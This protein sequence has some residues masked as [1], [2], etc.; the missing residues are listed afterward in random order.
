MADYL[1]SVGTEVSDEL[2]AM[3]YVSDSDHLP[4]QVNFQF[5]PAAGGVERG[6]ILFEPY[7]NGVEVVVV[8]NDELHVVNKKMTFDDF[9]SDNVTKLVL[10]AID[11]ANA[12]LRGVKVESK[13]LSMRDLHKLI[14]DEVSAAR[15][16]S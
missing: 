6:E 16:K 2:F 13:K 11:D 7:G 10:D 9:T 12:M 1:E 5:T 14:L 4:E 3:G 15:R 8:I